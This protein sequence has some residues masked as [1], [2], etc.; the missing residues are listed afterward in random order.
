MQLKLTNDK[1][2]GAFCHDAVDFIFEIYRYRKLH[3]LQTIKGN[4]T[5]DFVR[6]HLV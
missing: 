1:K 4:M 6:P 2:T 5:P 3:F